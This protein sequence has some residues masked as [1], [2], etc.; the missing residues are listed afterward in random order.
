[1]Q[2]VVDW[3]FGRETSRFNSQRPRL[4]WIDGFM[5][6]Q[7]LVL[8][9]SSNIK[10]S[11]AS[12]NEDNLTSFFN[13]LEESG[14][15]NIPPTNIFNHDETVLSDDPGAQRILSRRGTRR[16]EMV[17]E[18]SKTNTSIMFCGSVSGHLLPPYVVYK[19][20]N[21]YEGWTTG[22]PQGC[23]FN[24]TK[25]G[26]FDKPTF[27][28]WF[29]KLFIPAVAHLPGTKVAIGDNLAAHFSVEV[30]QLAVENNIM[31]IA[32]PANSTYL[33]QPLDLAVFR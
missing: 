18:H 13:E 31:F 7:N 8:R 2:T 27:E 1:M 32:L 22:A 12:I 10:R 6:R 14:I 4:D 21:L 17:R 33:L 11:R 28:D 3:G 20:A 5:K 19:A 15:K 9:K 24:V 30:V 23:L 16:V 26:W 25:S 29:R